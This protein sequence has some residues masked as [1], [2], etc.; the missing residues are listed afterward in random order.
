[1]NDTHWDILPHPYLLL[2][3]LHPILDRGELPDIIK[4][5]LED[6]TGLA[7]VIAAAIE[8]TECDVADVKYATRLLAEHM[9]AT[10]ALWRQW[11]EQ[12]EEGKAA[13]A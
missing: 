2:A 11:Q 13:E 5:L 1:M 4:R 3:D 8:H 9:H 10:L 12:E 7:G 6:A